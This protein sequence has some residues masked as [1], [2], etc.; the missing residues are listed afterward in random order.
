MKV[1]NELNS[2]KNSS[3]YNHY[4]L[5]DVIV[6]QLWLKDFNKK[7]KFKFLPNLFFNIN[8]YLNI[9]LVSS[10]NIIQQFLTIIITF[11]LIKT[12]DTNLYGEYVVILSFVNLIV[13]FTNPSLT[14]FFIREVLRNI[15]RKD[16]K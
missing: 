9:I 7:S 5:W 1:Q 11:L 6:L 2:F 14:P 3:N 4:N 15:K 12:F 16:I 10:S 13:L 8:R